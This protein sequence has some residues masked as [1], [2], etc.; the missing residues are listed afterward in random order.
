VLIDLLEAIRT[1]YA[2]AARMGNDLMTRLD[3]IDAERE[4]WLAALDQPEVGRR[5]QLELNEIDELRPR[6]DRSARRWVDR[7]RALELI[8]A[9]CL[10]EVRFEVSPDPRPRLMDPDVRDTVGA[11]IYA[12]EVG[13]STPDAS[14]T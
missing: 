6:I 10:K 12:T 13:C 3:A 1:R 8:V 5:A 14:T 7:A 11:G 2:H 9:A 4:Q